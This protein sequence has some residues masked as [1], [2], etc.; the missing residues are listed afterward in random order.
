MLVVDEKPVTRR[1]LET[2]YAT[3]LRLRRMGFSTLPRTFGE[4]RW[5]HRGPIHVIQ[6][7]EAAGILNR[8][9]LAIFRGE[10]YCSLS[11][12]G[13]SERAQAP[14]SKQRWEKGFTVEF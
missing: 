12:L 11:F 13:G 9:E 7:R 2:D 10:R 1:S 3:S 5:I 6:H 14:N 8:S 4:A